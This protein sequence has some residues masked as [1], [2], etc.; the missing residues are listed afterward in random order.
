[1]TEDHIV[2]E[3]RRVRRQHAEEFGYDLQKIFA[4]L[5]RSERERDAAK[6]PLLSPPKREVTPPESSLRRVRFVRR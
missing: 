6:S 5:K 1:M 4:D 3:V 2:E